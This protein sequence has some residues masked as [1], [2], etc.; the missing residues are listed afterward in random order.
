MSDER[1]PFRPVVYARDHT[2]QNSRPG[3]TH[4]A[5]AM[6]S[7]AADGVLAA[8]DGRIVLDTQH[9][10]FADEVGHLCERRGCVAARRSEQSAHSDSGGAE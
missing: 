9:P 4:G 5:Y 3:T 2:W 1:P 6:H 10:R 8:C 7:V